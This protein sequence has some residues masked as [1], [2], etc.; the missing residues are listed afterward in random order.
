MELGLGLGIGLRI[1]MGAGYG[2]F[3]LK[4]MASGEFLM[5]VNSEHSSD[6]Q[7]PH[8]ILR[9]G[10]PFAIGQIKGTVLTKL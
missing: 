10:S 1:G 6:L 5:W 4:P 3:T 2:A 8:C 7:L 9:M